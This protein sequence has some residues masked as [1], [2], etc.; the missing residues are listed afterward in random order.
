MFLPSLWK[1]SWVSLAFVRLVSVASESCSSCLFSCFY[2][3]FFRCAFEAHTNFAAFTMADY[4]FPSQHISAEHHHTSTRS[5]KAG[6]RVD[7][8]ILK[9]SLSASDVQWTVRNAEDCHHLHED[10]SDA[11][12]EAPVLPV[13]GPTE[14]ETFPIPSASGVAERG[15]PPP[16]PPRPENVESEMVLSKERW[17]TPS[18]HL[19]LHA[20]WALAK[21]KNKPK[22][23]K[24]ETQRGVQ[25]ATDDFVRDRS[26]YKRT[27]KHAREDVEMH[28]MSGALTQDGAETE[29]AGSF[30][31]S[32]PSLPES[33]TMS[34]SDAISVSGAISEPTL[35]PLL[36]SQDSLNQRCDGADPSP[37]DDVD[38]RLTQAMHQ[39]SPSVSVSGS[40]YDP[41]AYMVGRQCD[42]GSIDAILSKLDHGSDGRSV[43][44]D[45][46][47]TALPSEMI[48]DIYSY[49]GPHDFNAA[50]HTCRYWRAASLRLQM[51]TEQ[52][53]RGG[54]W[55]AASS[56]LLPFREWRPWYVH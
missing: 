23:N 55:S 41:G 17:P 24:S 18:R 19:D 8:R 32:S 22:P 14:P 9:R 5:G 16:L 33:D 6:S 12:L 39:L 28:V 53:K 56:E 35:R 47:S 30:M 1:C 51:L 13:P 37:T 38:V 20:L 50:R 10:G 34:V 27:A 48:Q 54:W 2:L 25:T 42:L 31:F 15:C 46:S 11:H 43:A 49:L 45:V 3:R 44:S 29:S 7:H 40:H 52:L 4:S 36:D 21:R 26:G